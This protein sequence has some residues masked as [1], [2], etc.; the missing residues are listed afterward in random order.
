M[1][2]IPSFTVDH[3]LIVPGI[4]ESR[5]DVLGEEMVTTFDV[6]IKRPNAEPALAPAVMHTME[7]VVATY[8]RNHPEWK[9]EL[10]YWGPMGCLTG[11]Y[12]IVKGRPAPSELYPILLE[13]FRHMRDFE[14]EVPGATAVN[15]GN[16][17][18]HDLPMAKW[19]AARYVTYLEENAGRNEIFEY[20]QTERLKLDGEQ[21]FFDS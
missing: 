2:L 1:D 7:H 17:L 4:F 14:G 13:S 6:R 8:L 10:I 11:F 18:L 12:I 16:Y 9:D 21:E 15:C 19:E 20:P 3:T 5:V